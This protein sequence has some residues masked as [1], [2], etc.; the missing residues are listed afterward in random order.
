[1]SQAMWHNE[2][3]SLAKMLTPTPLVSI[4][5]PAFN[6]AAYIG[7]ALDSVFLQTFEDYEVIVVNDGSPD[8]PEI[9]RVI[10]GYKDRLIYIRQKNQGPAAARNTAILRASGKYLALLDADDLWFPQYLALQLRI[11]E[12]NPSIDMVCADAEIIG[13]SVL[14][15]KTFFELWPSEEPVTFEKLLNMNCA[16]L[17]MGVVAHRQVLIQAGL[18]DTS[19]RR[20]EDY[21]LWLRLA[22]EGKRISY[23]NQVIGKHRY[24][25]ASLAA[26]V[27]RLIESQV[28]V[29]KKWLA[30][31]GLSQETR[32]LIAQQIQSCNARLALQQGRQ[33]L[34]NGNYVEAREALGHANCYYPSLKL[35]LALLGLQLWPRFFRRLFHAYLWLTTRGRRVEM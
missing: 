17:T 32:I 15:G 20:S 8:T 4:I 33:E 13:D 26:D 28:R 27:R 31:E 21:E 18:F 6:C 16:I 19:F 24:H 10:D 5:V 25:G 2:N 22:Y 1:M 35:K 11:L 3:D 9:E 34:L 30:K 12:D 23:N 14:A 7:E 29:Y